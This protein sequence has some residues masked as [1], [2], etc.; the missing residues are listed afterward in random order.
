MQVYLILY[1][2]KEYQ[3]KDENNNFIV[4]YGSGIQETSIKATI[5]RK[6]V[7]AALDYTPP[8]GYE[9]QVYEFPSM[10]RILKA[11]INWKYETTPA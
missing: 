2:G 8:I 11:D 1:V 10:K 3:R 5:D 9:K 7:L 6:E 4:V